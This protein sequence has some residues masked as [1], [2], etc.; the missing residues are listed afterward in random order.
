MKSSQAGELSNQE[1]EEME[2]TLT[3]II[4]QIRELRERMKSDDA[5]IARLKAETAELKADTRAILANLR[6]AA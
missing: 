2:A 4:E 3:H 6:R 1:A 5:E